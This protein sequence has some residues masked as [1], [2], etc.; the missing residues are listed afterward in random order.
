MFLISNLRLLYRGIVINA[1][2]LQTNKKFTLMRKQWVER[3][4]QEW[5][6]A[7]DLKLNR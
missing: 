2:Q 3:S 5:L 7:M 1:T 6:A 4:E